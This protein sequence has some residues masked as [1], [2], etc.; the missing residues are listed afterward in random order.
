LLIAGTGRA[1]TSF[2][3][4]ALAAFG[5]ETHLSRS[6]GEEWYQEAQAGLEDV[7][8]T[9]VSRDL[10][11]VVKTPWAYQIIDEVLADPGIALDA[12]VIPMR[13]LLEASASR[14]IVELSTL[15]RRSPWMT[16]LEKPWSDLGCTP[17][18]IVYSLS[19]VDQAR[20]LAVGFHHLVERLVQA[21][22]PLIFLAFP[23]M[24]EDA[25]Y[26]YEKLRPFLPPGLTREAAR[27]AHRHIAAVNMVRVGA[28]L[29]RESGR[30]HD[31]GAA[32]RGSPSLE[33]LDNIALR[34]EVERLRAQLANAGERNRP[35]KTARPLQRALALLAG[36]L[37]A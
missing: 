31:L 17:G 11:Y 19:P 28:E 10:P 20:L 32:G 23:R 13:D 36:W 24:V 12:V 15:H 2:L 34:R 5:L 21:D 3:V 25:D 7:P 22:V 37:A 16:A 27:Q 18:G 14:T 4:R 33:R 30:V 1:G 29:H 6:N 9:A 8:L 26:L 35:R